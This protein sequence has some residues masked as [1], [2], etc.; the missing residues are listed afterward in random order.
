MQLRHPS[1]EQSLLSE[2]KKSGDV[3]LVGKLFQPYL[4]LVLGSCYKYLK[5]RAESQDAAMQIFEKLVVA[6]KTHEITH[7]KSWLYTL[8]KNHCLM[9]LRSQKGKKFVEID[10]QLMESDTEPH[11][12]SDEIESNLT[13][14][15][16]CIEELAEEQK[17]CVQLFYLQEKCY[18]EIVDVSGLDY[19]QVKSHIQNGKR[20]LKICMERNA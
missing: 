11:P 14:L 5:D 3:L 2:Y 6:L 15:E 18:K 9:H 17:R 8:T 16:K 20:N 7:F 12:E 10:A 13:K 19:N 4:P 1:D